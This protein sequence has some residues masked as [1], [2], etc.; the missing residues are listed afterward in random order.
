MLKNIVFLALFCLFTLPSTASAYGS[1]YQNQLNNSL[2]TYNLT[3]N[4]TPY[5]EV[6][7]I[8]I[9]RRASV[10]SMSSILMGYNGCPAN[11]TTTTC[12]N[13]INTTNVTSMQ[14]FG[15]AWAYDPSN[16]IDSS[17]ATYSYGGWPGVGPSY[18]FLNWSVP[19]QAIDAILNISIALGTPRAFNAS[20]SLSDLGCFNIDGKVRLIVSSWEHQFGTDF[21][22]VTCLNSTGNWKKIFDRNGD[23][24]N[25]FYWL[26]VT[27]VNA[28]PSNI[29]IDIG[30]NGVIEYWNKTVWNTSGTIKF[31]STQ[32]AAVNSYLA[33]TCTA[34]WMTG[35]CD[36]PFNITSATLGILG[37]SGINVSGTYL[38]VFVT[39]CSLPGY[40]YSLNFTYKHE[41]TLAKL[42][43]NASFSFTFRQPGMADYVYNA[44]QNDT[45]YFTVCLLN[46]TYQTDLFMEY[47]K[48]GYPKRYYFMESFDVDSTMDDIYLYLLPDADVS[49]VLFTVRDV[50]QDPKSDIILYAQRYFPATTEYRTVAMGKT[51]PEGTTTIQLKINEWYK[52]VLLE[53]G[54]IVLNTGPQQQILLSA[55]L[56]TGAVGELSFF[57]YIGS[58]ATNCYY[59]TSTMFF[60]CTYA[61]SSGK[62][63]EMNLTIT[64]RY[65]NATSWLTIC[66]KTSTS[67]SAT[68]SCNLTDW[69]NRTLFY[70]L[71]GRQCCSETTLFTYM[72]GIITE[73]SDMLRRTIGLT[74]ILMAG[75]LFLT[76]AGIGFYNPK[77]AVAYGTVV[78]AITGPVMGILPIT[79]PVTGGI[80]FVAAVLIY[81]MGGHYAKS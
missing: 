57:N 38:E 7:W 58:V 54:A 25:E 11:L 69:Q 70:E 2:T 28:F 14:V 62:V 67:V 26:N 80:I 12:Y 35:T 71:K 49:E 39:N 42:T 65:L 81:L 10:S 23:S 77:Y 36:V 40:N 46:G 68:L 75:F 29:T 63:Q 37:I 5:Q 33:S 19:I 34:D 56:Y 21:G 31:N 22:N 50:Y 52:Y 72:S 53:G 1:Y 78:F 4:A 74:A 47:S 13:Y 24:S 6:V 32:L 16:M 15:Y 59:N 27:F 64:E 17:Y 30:N 66:K 8:N 20:F 43:G 18:V 9:P 76:I 48:T 73:L 3:F 79:W 51:G 44:S 45:Y 61:D 55:T 41:E 60:L